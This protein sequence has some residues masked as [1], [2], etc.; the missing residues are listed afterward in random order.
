MGV[1]TFALRA[2][3]LLFADKLVLPRI[4]ERA[5]NYVPAAVLAAI[6]TPALLRSEGQLDLSLTNPRLW[7]GMIAALIAWRSRSILLTIVV[8]ML[9]LWLLQRL[10]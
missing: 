5:L 1:I 9:G 7:A 10:I 3:F 6:V 8:G 4:L 2:S